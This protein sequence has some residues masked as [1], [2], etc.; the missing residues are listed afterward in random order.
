M[1]RYVCTFVFLPACAA[2]IQA[3]APTTAGGRKAFDAANDAWARG[4][5]IAALN[6]YTDLLSAPDGDAFLE[7]IALRTGELFK[8]YELTAD[9]RAGRFN[10]GGK[11]LVYETGL[12]VSQQTWIL[13]NDATRALVTELPG[14]SAT[15]SADSSKVVYLKIPVN[16]DIAAAATRSPAR[17]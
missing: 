6:A 15:F 4:D 10:P 14:V 9:G 8:T 12:E 16:T 17:H 13:R 5:Y 2:G 1:R 11:F 7:P 3:L